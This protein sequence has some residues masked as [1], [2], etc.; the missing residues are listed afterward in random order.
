MVG[1]RRIA[2]PVWRMPAFRILIVLWLSFALPVTALAS[3]MSAEHCHRGMPEKTTSAHSG[4]TMSAGMQMQGG[5]HADH[6]A[7][8][9]K[10]V[11]SN[12]MH[13]SCGCNCSA[14]HCVTTY[15]AVIVRDG[16]RESL[17]YDRD[18]WAIA[19]A[20]THPLAAHLRDILRPPSL[21]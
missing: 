8:A 12:N 21:S 18:I 1:N 7:S 16:L 4:H 13:C 5:E 15:S 20:S 11:G 3:L 2:V 9:G 10:A 14:S 17:A 6:M 19:S